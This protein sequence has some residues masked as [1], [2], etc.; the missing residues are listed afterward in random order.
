[1]FYCIH[2]TSVS[3]INWNNSIENLICNSYN[4]SMINYE[5]KP[6]ETLSEG[7]EN[8]YSIVTML[9]SPEGCPWDRKQTNKSITEAMIDECYEYLDGV[10]KGSVESSRE[11]IGD[12][13]INVF[14]TLLIHEEKKDFTPVEALNEVCEK[15]VRRHPHVFSSVEAENAEDALKTWNSVKEKVE[16]KKEKKEDFFEHIASSLPPMEEAYE[17]QKKLKKVGFDW[18]EV[19]G[20][21]SKVEEE[22][23]EVRK[24]VANSDEDNIEEEI[25]DLLFSVVNL[26]RFL[27]V[28]PNVA[29]RRCNNKI[30]DRFQKLFD[31]ASERGIPLDKDHFEEMDALWDEIKRKE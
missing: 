12:V 24:A 11:E 30:K 26:S 3:G 31:L 7:V 14:M 19:D 5:F 28:R 6:A 9:R 27:K 8:L 16:G 17:I 18:S 21:I 2:D 10:Q 29:M 15:L 22:L 23:E 25:G 20:V 4:Q 13:M 1:M